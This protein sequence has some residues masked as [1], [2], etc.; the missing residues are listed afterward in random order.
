MATT[1]AHLRAA[2]GTARALDHAVQAASLPQRP[3]LALGGWKASGKD[4]F[5]DRLVDYHGWTKLA[6]GE[7][8]LE[9]ML[10]ANPWIKVQ[11]HEEARLGPAL[12]GR[13]LLTSHLRASQIVDAVG[14][15]QAKTI[16][17]FRDFMLTFSDGVKQVAGEAVW[18]RAMRARLLTTT[19]PVV[20]TGC[21]MPLE[22]D[23]FESFGATTI[24]IERPGVTA[25]EGSHRTE[26]SLGPSDFGSIVHND[27]TLVAL[28]ACADAFVA[29]LA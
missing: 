15:V 25:P 13:R 26:T 16:A 2:S 6:M 5:A 23:L 9:A 11:P 7:L 20:F 3:I 18:V 29:S 21:R 22:L 19:G 1:P 10:V 28:H 12:A 24:W 17:E 14:Y 27:S 8:I 4:A